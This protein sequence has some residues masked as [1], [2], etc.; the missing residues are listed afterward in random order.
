MHNRQALS[1]RTK[2]IQDQN[3]RIHLNGGGVGLKVGGAGENR[4]HE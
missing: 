4:T 1:S 3:E 2:H